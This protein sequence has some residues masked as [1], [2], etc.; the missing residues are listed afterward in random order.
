MLVAAQMRSGL[1]DVRA[2]KGNNKTKQRVPGGLA[3]CRHSTQPALWHAMVFPS[4]ASL[5]SHYCLD[6]LRPQSGTRSHT[7]VTAVGLARTANKG[8]RGNAA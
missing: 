2:R 1:A 6:H 4:V 8:S 5:A 3:L 7:E